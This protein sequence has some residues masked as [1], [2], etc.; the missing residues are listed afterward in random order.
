MRPPEGGGPC[1]SKSEDVI[2]RSCP[3]I[4]NPTGFFAKTR[5]LFCTIV[6]YNWGGGREMV[7][8]N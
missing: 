6:R 3:G 1:M 2:M 5:D 7:V 4:G 8:C